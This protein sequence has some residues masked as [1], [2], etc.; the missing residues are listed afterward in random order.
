MPPAYSILITIKQKRSFVF[1]SASV[2]LS[3]LPIF[4]KYNLDVYRR[5][6]YTD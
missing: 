6:R 5:I 1:I 3:L 4:T 2:L